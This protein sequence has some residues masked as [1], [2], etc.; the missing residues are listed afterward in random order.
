[1]KINLSHVA[2]TAKDM[3]K[4][5]DFYTRVMGFRRVFDINDQ[6][7]GAPHIVY[8]SMGNDQFIELF[9]GGEE[10]NIWEAKQRGF[11]HI[12]LAVDDIHEMIRKIEEAGY[13][14]TRELKLGPDNNW[15]FWVTDPDDVRIEI[16]QIDPESPHGKVMAENAGK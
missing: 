4:S 2:V 15:Q 6:K 1:M 16:M 13:P 11:S 7:T 8:L 9:Y 3:E 5:L 14:I 10:D 12:C